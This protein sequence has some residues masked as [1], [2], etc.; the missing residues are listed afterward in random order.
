[1]ITPYTALTL[2]DGNSRT[3]R[4]GARWKVSDAASLSLERTREERGGDE[5]DTNAVMLRF[6]A[7]F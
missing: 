1:M 3:W 2:N 4:A 6:S 5:A 7:R